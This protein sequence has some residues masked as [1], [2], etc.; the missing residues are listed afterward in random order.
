MKRETSYYAIQNVCRSGFRIWLNGE[1]LEV[2][3]LAVN[4]YKQ[5]CR[6][7]F[8]KRNTNF[9][10][11]FFH[12]IL[13]VNLERRNAPPNHCR[14]KNILRARKIISQTYCVPS[15]TNHRTTNDGCTV[16]GRKMEKSVINYPAARRLYEIVQNTM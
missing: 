13:D 9:S 15:R 4:K 8:P 7:A 1:T 11:R 6:E 14:F 12:F 16:V 3:L 2:Q 10:M 5:I